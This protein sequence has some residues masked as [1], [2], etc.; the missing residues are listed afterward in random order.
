M[1]SYKDSN[2][3]KLVL[4]P[5]NVHYMFSCK[6]VVYITGPEQ[7]DTRRRACMKLAMPLRTYSVSSF[8]LQSDLLLSAGSVFSVLRLL[9]STF[10]ISMSTSFFKI[11]FLQLKK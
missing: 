5:F 6:P 10:P 7:R 8:V 11:R 3:S 1:D 2:I 9:L 4:A